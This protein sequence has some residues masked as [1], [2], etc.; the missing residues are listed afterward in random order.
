[1][2]T[3]TKEAFDSTAA[4]EIVKQ[5]EK[6]PNSVLGL[7]T[8]HTPKGMY[9]VLVQMYQEKKID[10]SQVIV[11]NLDEYF[12][13]D[14]DHP[15]TCKGYLT[16]RLY[17][18]VNLK[19]ENIY[20]LNSQPASGE[21]E[22]KRYDQLIN[23][24]GGID[25]LILGIGKNGHLGFNE[26]GT[27]L[28]S[29]THIIDLTD[30]SRT[31][32]A[33]SFGGKENVPTQG[34]TMGIKTIMNAKKLMM[35]ANGENKADIVEKAFNGPVTSDVPASVLQIHNNAVVILDKEAA[36]KLHNDLY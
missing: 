11:L 4:V 2:I 17:Q 23:Q 25:F 22:C 29:Q 36:S 30:R 5:I 21:E 8:G 34:I 12:G 26:P 33:W 24:L 1:M 20:Y 32:N 3:D 28:E 16:E 7:A 15:G 31:D 14:S 27:S 35:M 13:A 9:E 6:K 10:F 18:H 19:K